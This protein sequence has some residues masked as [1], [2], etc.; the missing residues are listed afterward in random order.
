MHAQCCKPSNYNA[1][2]VDARGERT[3]RRAPASAGMS[4]SSSSTAVSAALSIHTSRMPCAAQ[5]AQRAQRG[6]QAS[7]SPAECLQALPPVLAA[8]REL[9]AP[10]AASPFLSVHNN[11][12]HAAAN[13]S[14]EACSTPPAPCLYERGVWEDGVLVHRG[15]VAVQQ[16]VVQHHCRRA[17]GAAVTC[18]L[19][20]VAHGEGAWRSRSGA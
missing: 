16:A 6:V 13:A 14:G 19:Q 20:L 11:S 2:S 10:S 3:C 5:R 7:R 1:D 4:L 8:R 9:P 18:K 12:C 15:G 17:A